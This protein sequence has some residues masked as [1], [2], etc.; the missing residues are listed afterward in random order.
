M[1]VPNDPHTKNM[2]LQKHATHFIQIKSIQFNSLSR[3]KVR[4]ESGKCLLSCCCTTPL[5]CLF[6][7]RL[8]FLFCRFPRKDG[9]TSNLDKVLGFWK[10]HLP[11][12]GESLLC[13]DGEP[14]VEGV[15]ADDLPVGRGHD[16]SPHASCERRGHVHRDGRRRGACCRL[17]LR[18]RWLNAFR[19]NT[20]IPLQAPHLKRG[21]A[22]ETLDGLCGRAGVCV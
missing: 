15:V 2:Q 21:L 12:L 6:S 13:D 10:Q 5:L 22:S 9:W 8:W 7:R 16:H 17:V 18:P 20:R 1:Y 11:E 3:E 14:R 19:H 4:G